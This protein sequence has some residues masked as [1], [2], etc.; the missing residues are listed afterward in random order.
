M[1]CL[2]GQHNNSQVFLDV[3]IIDASSVTIS[4]NAL[5]RVPLVAPTMFKALVDTGATKT[6]ISSDVAA[7]L[8]LAAVGQ[9]MIQGAGSSITY[10][11]GY[12]FHV[13]FLLPLIAPGQLLTPGMQIQAA[14]HVF[15]APIYGGEISSGRGFD[16][17]LGMDII[18]SGSLKVEGNGTFS[19]SF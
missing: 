12:L 4:G 6:M 18:S 19:F 11:N 14:L 16:V 17:L 2:Y 15:P 1:P 8:S 13:A 3:G 5:I 7:R 9:V 10:H